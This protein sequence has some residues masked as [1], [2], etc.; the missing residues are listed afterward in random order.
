MTA[1]EY[2]EQYKEAELKVEQLRIEYRKQLEKADTIRSPLDSDGSQHSG[3]VSNTT[4]ERA[5]R[6]ADKAMELKEAEADALEIR[7]E[8]YNTVRQ[9]QGEK[10]AILYERYINLKKWEDVAD[11]V[12]YSERH[13]YNLHDEALEEVRKIAV[14]CS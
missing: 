13:V 10:G 2:L 3:S 5:V 9:V 14:Y 6:L 11:A 1:R 12:G 8:I 4:A 7:Q